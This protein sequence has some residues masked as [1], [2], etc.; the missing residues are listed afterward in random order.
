MPSVEQERIRDAI[1]ANPPH[2]DAILVGWVL[3]AEWEAARGERL[4]SRLWTEKASSWQVKGYLHEGLF[5]GWPDG[6][7]NR[8]AAGG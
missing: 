4:L 6:N 3:I 1:R 5:G 8:P 7:L 2:P